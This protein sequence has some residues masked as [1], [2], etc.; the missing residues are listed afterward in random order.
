MQSVDYDETLTLAYVREDPSAYLI[1][2]LWSREEEPKILESCYKELFEAELDSWY[3]D[4]GL[5][6]QNRDLKMFLEW[7]D[8]EFLSGVYD[9]LD[10]PIE[11]LEYDSEDV[12]ITGSN[13]H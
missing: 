4:P 11:S 7:F 1:P 5:W 2:E 8:V 12:D 3:T 6:P 13:G 10:D 9:L